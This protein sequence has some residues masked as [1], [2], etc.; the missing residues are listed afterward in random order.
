MGRLVSALFYPEVMAC[1]IIDL[2]CHTTSRHKA[3]YESM[4]L[5]RKTFHFESLL[6]ERPF[7]F[8]I[9]LLKIIFK[10]NP[11]QLFTM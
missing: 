2:N 10:N 5:I 4:P 6:E 8:V 1:I 11:I 3:M 7:D 9:S